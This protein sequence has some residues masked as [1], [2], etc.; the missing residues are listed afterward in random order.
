MLYSGLLHDRAGPRSRS[1]VSAGGSQTVFALRADQSFWAGSP[2]EKKR[3]RER[4]EKRDNSFQTPRSFTESK[5]VGDKGS[6]SDLRRVQSNFKHHRS[7]QISEIGAKSRKSERANRSRWR[8]GDAKSS[9]LNTTPTPTDDTT[10][11]GRTCAVDAVFRG[12]YAGAARAHLEV[13]GRRAARAQ[14]Y[15]GARRLAVVAGVPGRS[16]MP[17]RD[18]MGSAAASASCTPGRLPGVEVSTRGS[19]MAG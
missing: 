10:S 11:Q 13:S 18:G 3:S 19:T 12:G 15:C 9:R 2:I 16:T 7:F 5:R 1:R 17:N 6:F 8:L 14:R 4:E